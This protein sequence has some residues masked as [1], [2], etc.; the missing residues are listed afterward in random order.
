M[1][2][3]EHSSRG[4][5]GRPAGWGLEV[6][7]GPALPRTTCV[8]FS[9]WHQFPALDKWTLKVTMPDSDMSWFPSI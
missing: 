3:S 2:S 9:P 5:A 6:K 8:P 7:S 4:P 1:K